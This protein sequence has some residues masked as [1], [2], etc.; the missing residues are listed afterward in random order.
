MNVLVLKTRYKNPE[1]GSQERKKKSTTP[2][3]QEKNTTS[4]LL[5]S[6]L[7]LLLLFFCFLHVDVKKI[8][9]SENG[10]DDMFTDEN[11]KIENVVQTYDFF[12][13]ILQSAIYFCM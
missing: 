8:I 1:T 10:K 12:H 13:L 4:R 9:C 3:N 11:I 5:A 6:E 2:T 7:E